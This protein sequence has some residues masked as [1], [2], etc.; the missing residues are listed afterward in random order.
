MRHSQ[1]TSCAA[2]LPSAQEHRPAGARA[3]HSFVRSLPPACAARS[4]APVPAGAHS[5]AP[6]CSSRQHRSHPQGVL[7][8]A[9]TN[10]RSCRGCSAWSSSSGASTQRAARR[11]PTVLLRA[12]RPKRCA[13][14]HACVCVC[15][16]AGMRAA[17]VRACANACLGVVRCGAVCGVLRVSTRAFVHR[18][19][20]SSGAG[21]SWRRGDG[22]ASHLPRSRAAGRKLPRVHAAAAGADH[23]ARPPRRGPL[24]LRA[25]RTCGHVLRRYVIHVT[26]RPTQMACHGWK[27]RVLSARSNAVGA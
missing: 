25:F 22:P 19:L 3:Q 5:R 21:R 16:R 4:A 11:V 27:A 26:G 14:R 23:R 13:R 17:H 9:A 15:V 10:W 7:R 20:R 18:S 8:S 24:G 12:K 1:S 2:V 6:V